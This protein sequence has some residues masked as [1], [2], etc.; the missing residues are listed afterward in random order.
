ALSQ[1]GASDRAQE[2]GAASDRTG[3]RRLTAA[4]GAGACAHSKA[5]RPPRQT[6]SGHECILQKILDTTRGDPQGA[7]RQ[8][9]IA[10]EL[11]RPD[12]ATA[13]LS[14]LTWRCNLQRRN[15]ATE[16]ITRSP[17]A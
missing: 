12:R 1:H 4:G 8:E 13:L 14:R 3:R 7:I 16:A 2:G 6:N 15:L 5:P 17:A 10:E 9:P 11:A